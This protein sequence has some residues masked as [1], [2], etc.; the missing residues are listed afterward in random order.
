MSLFRF[1]ALLRRLVG[2][3]QYEKSLQ[4]YTHMGNLGISPDHF[5]FPFVLKAC[6]CLRNIPFGIKL[7]GHVIVNGYQ[8][9]VFVA[10]SLLA[11]Y[12]RCGIF[13]SATQVFDEMPQRNAVS[14]STIIGACAQSL[15]FQQG[16]LF[17]YRMLNQGQEPNRGAIL[18]VLA[19]VHTKNVADDVYR[20]IKA[21]KLDSDL[22]VRNVAM[23]MYARCGCIDVARGIFDGMGGDK[24]LVFWTSMIKVYAQAELPL[25]ALS[26]FKQMKLEG[27]FP[28]SVT[29]LG[30]IQACSNLASLRQ[31]QTVHGVVIS[32]LSK[33]SIM[34]DTAVVDLYV[35]CGSL[36]CARK[37]FDGMEE[38]NVISWSTMIYGYGIHGFGNEAL[39]LYDQM[40]DS[41]KPDHVTFVSVLSACS[42]AGLITQGW[43]IFRSMSRD[44]GIKPRPEHYACMVDM[45]GRAGRLKEAQEFITGMPERPDAGVWGA[46]LGACRIHSNSELAE[47]AAE[48]LLNLDAENAGRYVIL[49]NIFSSSGRGKEADGIRNVMKWR[50]VRKTAGNAIIETCDQKS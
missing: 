26:L 36:A 12:A 6:G 19:C 18:N 28:D 47:T 48:S 49:S 35:K 27:V 46:L 38:R 22:S 11:M 24:D 31:A 7:H 39:D 15:S 23:L 3:A 45:L 17:F 43:E 14:W 41:I 5:T 13:D 33:S 20:V 42:H 10:N 2:D 25:E 29:L 30:L 1:N 37:V 44:F 40:K 9:D 50:G 32:S 4:L 21:H 8:S 16:I 34:V